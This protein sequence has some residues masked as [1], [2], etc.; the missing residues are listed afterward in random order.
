MIG[1]AVLVVGLLLILAGLVS[2]RIPGEATF[3]SSGISLAADGED[4]AGKGPFGLARRVRNPV[5]AFVLSPIHPQTWYANTAIGVGFFVGIFTFAMLASF[6]S[7]GFATIVAG[8]GVIVIALGIE[9]A[10]LVARF[11]RRRVMLG[12]PDHLLAHPY[13]SRS[14]GLV[15][16]LKAEFADENRWRDVLYVAVN[17]PLS[18]IE[19]LVVATIWAIS[20]WLLTMPLWY[21]AVTGRDPARLPRRDRRPRRARDPHPHLRRR[22]VAPGCGLGLAARPGAPSRGRHGPAMHV[23]EP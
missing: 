16:L 22:R 5:R 10:R 20:L 17:F 2:A 21:N 12:A 18:M 8:V 23:R 4:D 15:E 7:A 11:E 13:R 9:A 19:F 1:G 6:A 14:G 3:A